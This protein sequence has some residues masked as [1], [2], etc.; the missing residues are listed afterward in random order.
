MILN[1]VV[2]IC[3]SSSDKGMS[4]LLYS[5]LENRNVGCWM[6]THDISPGI[7]YARAIMNG[8]EECKAMLV[9]ISSHSIKS[10]DVL[11]EIDA[12]HSGKK[13]LIP[14]FLEKIDLPSDFSYYLNRR[15]WVIYNGN[16]EE[17]VSSIIEALK[18]IIE[19]VKVTSEYET[20]VYSE[21]KYNLKVKPNMDCFVFIDG[22]NVG[23]AKASKITKFPLAKG[24]YS[25]ACLF[26]GQKEQ[27]EFEDIIINDGDI[28]RKPL[29]PYIKPTDLSSNNGTV[30]DTE[31]SKLSRMSLRQLVKSCA[32]YIRVNKSDFG[33]YEHELG[34]ID[35]N[36]LQN[37]CMSKYAVNLE[38]SISDFNSSYYIDLDRLYHEIKNLVL[39]TQT[40]ILV[41]HCARFK[42]IKLDET[43]SVDFIDKGKLIY[44][45]KEVF[46]ANLKLWQLHVQ[47]DTSVDHIAKQIVD[48]TKKECLSNEQF[49]SILSR[50]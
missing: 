41:S 38:S 20:E 36:A 33:G 24:E 40:A 5:T 34:V 42:R 25:F 11:N 23:I 39:E 47:G 46:G 7:P 3:H 32:L 31:T 30:Q 22:E 14:I 18:D 12:A 13:L 2:F 48:L 26:S 49:M 44:L 6:D 43:F 27:V 37:V 4:E 10:D 16:I 17:C 50:W 28:L 1:K 15:Q 45:S 9:L 29:F 19:D 21:V 35:W 8:L